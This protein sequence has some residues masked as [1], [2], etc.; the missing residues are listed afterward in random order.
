MREFVPHGYSFF[1]GRLGRG[2]T[3]YIGIV[4]LLA[5]LELA[6]R[7]LNQLEEQA[8]ETETAT[9]SDSLTITLIY[10][11]DQLTDY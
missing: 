3:F 5:P 9:L 6:I 10:S 2:L 11:Y 4:G 1:K 7:G 8:L